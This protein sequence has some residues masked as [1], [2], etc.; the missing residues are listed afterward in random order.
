MT[1]SHVGDRSTCIMVSC[2]YDNPTSAPI[3]N[4]SMVRVR[5]GWKKHASFGMHAIL[6]AMHHMIFSLLW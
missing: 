1:R 6:A 3:G 4:P 5:W 2:R